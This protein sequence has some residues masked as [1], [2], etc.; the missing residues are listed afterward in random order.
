M[1]EREKKKTERVLSSA[2]SLPKGVQ[3]L[4]LGKN[5]SYELGTP[6]EPRTNTLV[7]S[8][9]DA[10]DPSICVISYCFLGSVSR[11]LAK[12][13]DKHSDM[14]DSY[15]RQQHSLMCHKAYS[16]NLHD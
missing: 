1:R 11:D 4:V 5:Q 3:Q 9:L 14:A 13:W 15:H 12:Q 16:S 7:V 6:F 2:G 8:H 10:K